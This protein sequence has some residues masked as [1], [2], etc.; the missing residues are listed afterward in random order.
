MPPA[1]TVTSRS[2]FVPL[3]V[4][5]AALQADCTVDHGRVHQT[6]VRPA[7]EGAGACEFVRLLT[8]TRASGEAARTV[9]VRGG[10]PGL[11]NEIVV[12]AAFS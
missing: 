4:K 9:K 6:V 10:G 12:T 7:R 3:R 1:G 5:P 8:G 2:R 11:R